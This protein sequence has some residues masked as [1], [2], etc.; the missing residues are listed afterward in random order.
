MR[1]ALP[2]L[3]L[4]VDC[5]SGRSNHASCYYHWLSLIC[6][7]DLGT[8]LLTLVF[9]LFVAG[10]TS[11]GKRITREAGAVSL[12][13]VWFGYRIR[14]RPFYYNYSYSSRGQC[15]ARR[16]FQAGENISSK[17]FVEDERGEGEGGGK[18]STT[19][20]LFLV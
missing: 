8:V 13:S 3:S 10:K 11:C 19:K 18:I 4:A 20:N 15:R 16:V 14:S 1:I 5:A 7:C 17:K 12:S 2:G 6:D 9:F